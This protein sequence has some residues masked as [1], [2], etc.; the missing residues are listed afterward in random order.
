MSDP[1]RPLARM[2]DEPSFDAAWQVEALA[3]ANALIEAGVIS[4]ND[5]S[6]G[7][8]Q[9]LREDGVS[10][11]VTGYY[12]AVLRNLEALLDQPELIPEAEQSSRK[13][14][15]EAAYLRTPHGKP[16]CL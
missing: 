3:M 14:E 9:K 11:D 8:G 16:V 6:E 1:L 2:N 7:L 12:R 5:W 10:D 13:A 4:A 15:W